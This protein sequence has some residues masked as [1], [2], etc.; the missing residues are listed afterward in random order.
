LPRSE[1]IRKVRRIVVKIGTSVITERGLI[2]PSRLSKLVREMVSIIQRGYEIVIVSS[3]AI[4]A[5]S[6][7]VKRKCNLLTIPD[8]QALA[9]V[10]QIALMNEY[11]KYFMRAGLEVG[12]ILLTEDDVN[13][14]RRY[15]N[16]RNTF[17]SLLKLGIVPIVN[18]NDSVVVKEIKFGDNDT[19]SAHV[20]NITEADLLILLSDVDGFYWDLADG[21]PVDEI[22]EIT[23][24][25][26]MRAGGAGSDY[27]TGGMVTKIRAAE[28][29]IRSGEMMI[30][31]NGQKRG[32]LKRILNGEQVGT[33]FYGKKSLSSRKRWIAFSQKTKGSIILDDGA[34]DALC[35]RKKSLLASGI[36]GVNG[37]FD[38]GDAVEMRD[39]QGRVLGKGIVNYTDGELQ[40]IMGKRTGE[41]KKIL[42]SNYFDE[43]INRDDLILY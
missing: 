31:A 27:G 40:R 17:N 4:S 39:T 43:V 36:T 9:S 28:I 1:H 14:R 7:L 18:E 8:K 32:I 33:L 23:E 12:Q 34:V 38:L 15:L 13:H 29:I 20:A 30:I 22:Q 16:A 2:A 10:G 6:A 26:I 5:G 41:I 37:S 35:N 19:L 25:V 3:G 21:E 24:D 11:R 42:G